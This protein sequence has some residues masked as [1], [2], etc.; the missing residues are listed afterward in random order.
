MST[1]RPEVGSVLELLGRH[2]AAALVRV[3]EA[4]ACAG[5]C[6]SVGCGADRVVESG[7]CAA[8]GGRPGG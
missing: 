8:Y 4:R 2:E 1:K 6:G 7:D 5:G 3:E